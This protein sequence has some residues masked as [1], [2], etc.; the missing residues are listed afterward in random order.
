MYSGL[1]DLSPCAFQNALIGIYP[2]QHGRSRGAADER[3]ECSR[4]TADV[5]DRVLGLR[6]NL[7]KKSRAPPRF[8]G[9]DR[10]QEV[11]E[12]ELRGSGNVIPLC[13]PGGFIR[14]TSHSASRRPTTLAP[15]PRRPAR[16]ADW[17]VGSRREV[18]AG[19]LRSRTLSRV[20]HA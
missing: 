11:V 7:T 16:S 1:R 20:A 4:A 2:D 19:A 15:E 10:D 13:R 14:H 17:G 8:T 18:L 3:E 12:P 6:V 9:Q 5:G